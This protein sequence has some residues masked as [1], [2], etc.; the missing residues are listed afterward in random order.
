MEGE[1]AGTAGM[2]GSAS[3][4]DEPRDARVLRELLRSMGLSEGE[5]EPRVVHQLLELAYRSVRFLLQLSCLSM[6]N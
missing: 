3:A 4:P 2:V 5:Y 1:G 6:R